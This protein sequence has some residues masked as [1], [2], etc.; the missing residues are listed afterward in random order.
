MP[1]RRHST[2]QLS[3][4]GGGRLTRE[5]LEQV[6]LPAFDNPALA[7]RHDS[8]VVTLGG[9]R[10]AMTTDSYVVAPRF[11]PGG[12]IGTLAMCGTVNDLLM[13]G[14]TPAHP[15]AGFVLEEGLPFEELRRVV[16][17]MRQTAA[18]CG[19]TLVAGD[20]M[21][22]RGKGDGLF[23]NTAGIGLVRDGLRLSPAQVRPGD[24]VLVSGDLGRHGIAVL[25]V[26]EG[27]AFDTPVESD[28]AAVFPL[29]DAL[30]AAGVDLHC[31]R[32]PTRGGLAAVLNE[33]ALDGNV[34][35]EVE[36]G[37]LPIADDVAGASELLG[38][39]P[40]HVACE[41]RMVVFL[42]LAQAERGLAA[43]RAHPLGARAARVGGVTAGPTRTV[44][45]R[46][47]LG[48]RRVL[49]LLSSE[50]LPRIC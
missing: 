13:A 15:S 9:A 21:V 18:A 17:S 19:V 12:D 22:D 8:A 47:R 16:T 36:E 1:I 5:R 4:G 41:G 33:V 40:L 3:H 43:L 50:Q 7:E 44:L 32:D 46:T 35:V 38:L 30:L 37:T 2:V 31:L 26:R 10:L 6:F 23:I 28:C 29:V 25:S 45:L 24:A 27:L 11:F 20:T 39:D 14:A 42:P 49:D 34:G 48:S